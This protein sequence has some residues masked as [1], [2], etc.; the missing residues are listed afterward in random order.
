MAENFT[1]S[2]QGTD[3]V[4]SITWDIKTGFENLDN[5]VTD[6][7]EEDRWVP[8]IIITSDG[9]EAAI[10]E[11]LYDVLLEIQTQGTSSESDFEDNA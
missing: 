7:A 3:T 1:I 2:F 10:E 6:E 5:V 4:D 9:V 8:E 11:F